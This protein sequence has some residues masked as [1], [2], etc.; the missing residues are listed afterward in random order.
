MKLDPRFWTKQPQAIKDTYEDVD[1]RFGVVE[2][3]S[4]SDW[5]DNSWGCIDKEFSIG[6]IFHC[7]ITKQSAIK[8]CQEF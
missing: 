4:I 3:K 8:F 6:Y 7:K 1:D 5:D 2:L